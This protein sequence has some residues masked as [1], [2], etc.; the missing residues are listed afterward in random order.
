MKQVAVLGVAQDDHFQRMLDVLRA[1]Y[2]PGVVIA[3]SSHPI[4]AGSPALLSNRK[5]INNKATTYVCEGFV[6]KL[7][8][9]E[10][11]GLIKQLRF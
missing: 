1:E 4:K 9:T 11:D 5:M 6:C 7:P 10:I 3:A 2:R 8:V